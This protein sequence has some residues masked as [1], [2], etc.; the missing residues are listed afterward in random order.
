VV[1]GRLTA[2]PSRQ[3]QGQAAVPGLPPGRCPPPMS[4]T[5]AGTLLARP[6]WAAAGKAGAPAL[7]YCPGSQRRQPSR[8]WP[9]A[10]WLSRGHCRRP[11]PWPASAAGFC[12][13]LRIASHVKANEARLG[14]ALSSRTAAGVAIGVIAVVAYRPMPLA[15]AAA[16]TLP[17][18]PSCWPAAHCP[19]PPATPRPDPAWALRKALRWRCAASRP[20]VPAATPNAGACRPSVTPPSQAV[21]SWRVRFVN[22]CGSLPVTAGYFQAVLVGARA[23]LMRVGICVAGLAG[24][25]VWLIGYPAWLPKLPG[26]AALPNTDWRRCA[27]HGDQHGVDAKLCILPDEAQSVS[28]S[29]LDVCQY[30]FI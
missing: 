26:R 4:T 17:T 28:P 2:Q 8:D 6:A 20:S 3:R 10:V 29:R 5:E 9:C 13:P 21:A 11:S 25:M 7:A 23:G 15:A 14:G 19:W 16:L 24:L 12:C 18:A 27:S 22:R 1:G 30:V